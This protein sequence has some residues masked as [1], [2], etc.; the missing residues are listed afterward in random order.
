[1]EYNKNLEMLPFGFK[2]WGATCYFNSLI[3]SLMSC[4]SFVEELSQ[5]KK[6]KTNP[7]SKLFIDMIENNRYYEDL[8]HKLKENNTEINTLLRDTKKKLNLYGS[9]IW[10]T[11]VIA[12]CEK[13][14]ISHQSFMQGMQCVG[15]GFHYLLESMELFHKIQN[16]FMH[17]YKSLIHC[18][19]CDEWV[20]DVD[21]MYS[22]FEIDPEFKTEQLEKFKK[23]HIKTD[24]L[25]KYLAKQSGYVDA[26]FI[27]PKCKTKDERY[28]VNLLVM[29]PKI[30][31]VMSKKYTPDQKL[32]VYTDFPERMEFKG[33][34]NKPMYYE[35]VAQIEHTGGLNGGHYWAICKRKGKWF[36]L[37]DMSVSPSEFKPTNNTYVVFYH[38][39]EF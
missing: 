11:M 21:C 31:V 16:L 6:Y 25:N 23:Y 34:D 36:N 33:N 7:V 2:N 39:K 24:T 13:K 30:L 14:K 19:V 32:D 20:S 27:C 29:V 3:Q 1:M 9:E 17:R 8:Y 37:N 28:I 18:Y 5:S 35:A 4:T 12:L 15:E 22:L 26:D 10:K 38:L